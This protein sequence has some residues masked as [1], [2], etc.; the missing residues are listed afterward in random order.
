MFVEVESEKRKI[1]E[2]VWIELPS[3]QL[4][5]VVLGTRAPHLL[6]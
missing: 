6:R 3:E 1:I 5:Q 4:L 2:R